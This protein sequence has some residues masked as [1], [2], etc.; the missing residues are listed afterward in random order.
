[1]LCVAIILKTEHV[2]QELKASKQTWN[3][4]KTQTRVI[5]KAKHKY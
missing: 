3:L 2:M 1:M 5:L 4:I